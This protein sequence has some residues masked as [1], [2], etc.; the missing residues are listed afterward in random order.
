M[1]GSDVRKVFETI[2]PDAALLALARSS[3]LQERAR[4]LD[5]VGLLRAM[6][7]AAATGYG[8]RQ[9]DVMR[10]YVK[11][12]Q[13]HVCD[14]RLKTVAECAAAKIKPRF[15]VTAITDLHEMHEDEMGEEYNNM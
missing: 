13:C 8:G 6:I 4:K 2:L 14:L 1:Q 15:V 5:A 9:A 10:L 7:I 11:S 3:M 12:M